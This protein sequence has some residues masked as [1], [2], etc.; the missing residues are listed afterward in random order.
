M[1]PAGFR[2]LAARS[3]IVEVERLRIELVGKRLDAFRTDSDAP[4]T[5]ELLA[6]QIILER[7]FRHL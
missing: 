7:V 6:R 3:R 1:P 5:R 2:S 4:A